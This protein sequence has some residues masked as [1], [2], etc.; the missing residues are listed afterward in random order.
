M[1]RLGCFATRYPRVPGENGHHGGENIHHQYD[2]D[3]VTASSE[4]EH[5]V[6]R[7]DIDCFKGTL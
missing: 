1:G 3:G 4:T 6:P 5:S 7:A 2:G